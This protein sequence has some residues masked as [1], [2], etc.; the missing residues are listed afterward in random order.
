MGLIS[1]EEHQLEKEKQR[2]AE[3]ERRNAEEKWNFINKNQFDNP[4]QD[5]IV[6]DGEA[7]APKCF[8]GGSGYGSGRARKFFMKVPLV[9]EVFF[10]Q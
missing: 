8:L 1:F 6:G 7:P 3:K 5:K 4:E 10:A 2:N 9:K